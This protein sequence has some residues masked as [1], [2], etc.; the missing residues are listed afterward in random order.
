MG[1]FSRLLLHDTPLK[2]IVAHKRFIISGV[3]WA[4][5][6]QLG[7]SSAEDLTVRS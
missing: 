1:H 6:V 5:W 7:G 2:N 3:L 4:D